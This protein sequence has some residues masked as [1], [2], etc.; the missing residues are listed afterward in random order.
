MAQFANVKKIR[1]AFGGTVNDVVLTAVMQGFSQLLEGRG[2]DVT[3]K[4]LHIMVPV[5][6]RARDAE[7]RPVG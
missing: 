4:S 2:R 7:G 5:A 6:L 3:G 1:S